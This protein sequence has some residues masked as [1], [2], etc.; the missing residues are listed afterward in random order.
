MAASRHLIVAE[1][2][3]RYSA[4]KG[5]EE[6]LDFGFD[7][8]RLLRG[9]TISTSVWTVPEGLTQ[10]SASSIAGARTTVWLAGGG[11]A[12]RIY[13]V[14]NAITTNTGRIHRRVMRIEVVE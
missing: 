2:L 6:S 3:P 11:A 4:W 8:S 1:G 7:W 9:D 10:P 13:E 12:G 5:I 14:A